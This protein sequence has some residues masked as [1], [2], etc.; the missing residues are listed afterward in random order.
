MANFSSGG[1]NNVRPAPGAASFRLGAK[2]TRLTSTE[3]DSLALTLRRAGFVLASC[4]FGVCS[5]AQNATVTANLKQLG[6]AAA[7]PTGAS[8]RVDLQNCAAPRI[9][10]TGNIG[11]KTR[12]FYPNT[13]GLVTITLY[14][15][16]VL[17]CGQGVLANP[18]SFYSFNLVANGQVTS[19]GSYKVP[20]GSTTLDTLT[21]INTTPVINTPTGDNTYL[22]LD[23]GN[24]GSIVQPLPPISAAS[25]NAVGAATSA[26]V[27]TNTVTAQSVNSVV[28][29]VAAG[30]LNAAA[31]ACPLSGGCTIEIN[32]AVTMSGNLTLPATTTLKFN[33][34][35]NINLAGFTLTTGPVEADAVPIFAS[36][37]VHLGAV[38]TQAPVEWFGAVGNGSTS[39]FAAIQATL[40]ALTAGQA[41]LQ[42]KKYSIGTNTLSITASSVGITGVASGI[43]NSALYPTPTA[44]QILS[45]SSTAD[46]LDVSGISISNHITY[47]KFTNFT[48][49]RNQAPGTNAAGLR[50]SFSYGAMIDGVVGEDS[51]ACFVFKGVGAQGTGYIQNS[52]CTWGYNGFTETSGS[53]A[54]FLID[55][56]SGVVSP[57]IRI[58]DSFVAANPAL[59]GATTYGL[60]SN[61]SAL[62]DTMVDHLETAT[63][64]Y[65]VFLQSSGGA[66]TDIHL[67]NGIN[68]GCITTCIYIQGI[69]G[70]AEVSGG[71]NFRASSSS[72]VIDI[73]NSANVNVNNLALFYPAGTGV[74]VS[75]L[76]SGSLQVNHNN[77]VTGVASAIFFTNVSASTVTGNV[78]NGITATNIFNLV[79]SVGNVISSNTINGTAACGI[80]LDATSSGNAGL[81]TNQ[82]G[83]PALGA[84]GT[85]VC[86]AGSNPLV[87]AQG[88]QA[89]LNGGVYKI[90]QLIR[91][92]GSPI[93]TAAANS[94][95]TFTLTWPKAFPDASWMGECTVELSAG[96][97]VIWGVSGTGKTS[98]TATV[99]Y[100]DFTGLSNMLTSAVCE[101]WE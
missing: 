84:I 1:R 82:I 86:N 100:R 10:G 39:D 21:P 5:F 58:R 57:S 80:A 24:W 8:I 55:S 2:H 70:S 37:T 56:T 31:S 15:N 32:N 61:G 52:A 68:D 74:G 60:E 7:Q 27:T 72:P 47:N 83:N 12:T 18:V 38:V 53:L 4:L 90:R 78:E 73:R 17:D 94:Q 35:G 16:S 6:G 87:A 23:L 22:R 45:T 46:I 95:C 101:G 3:R 99:F 26:S 77:F 96:T 40:N 54:G 76:T 25:V 43:P 62:Q 98:S 89:G 49:A 30:S 69:S 19:L 93:C 44:S 63:T 91:I 67:I 11:E 66:S 81:Q 42:A 75:A 33:Q 59:T 41:L 85:L 50:L 71:W 20:A 29:A 9:P 28:N 36:G 14:A 92:T 97:G 65:G 34:P 64:N 51:T 13:S 48:L 88:L 79:N